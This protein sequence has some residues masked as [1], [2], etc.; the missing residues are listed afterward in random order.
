MFIITL[1]L[2]KF[3]K[4][5]NVCTLLFNIFIRLNLIEE[6][7]VVQSR[8]WPK[9]FPFYLFILVRNYPKIKVSHN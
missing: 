2:I 6:N 4:D 1:N 3:K 9:I 7:N 8:I 5:N